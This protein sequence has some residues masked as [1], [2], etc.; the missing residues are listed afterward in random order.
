VLDLLAKLFGSQRAVTIYV[1]L[2]RRGLIILAALAFVGIV[3]ALLL[4]TGPGAHRHVSFIVAD[5]VRTMPVSQ[6]EKAGLIADLRLPDGEVVRVTTTEAPI[7]AVVTDTACI[8]KRQW[9]E[10]GEFRYRIKL[11]QNCSGG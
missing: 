8:E 6:N 11:P 1:F 9:L 5:V 2:K 3:G 4:Y 10:T 7:A